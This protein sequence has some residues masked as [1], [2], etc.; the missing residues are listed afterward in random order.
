[1]TPRKRGGVGG[2]EGDEGRWMDVKIAT[3]QERVTPVAITKGS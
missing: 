1:M 3:M 2:Y